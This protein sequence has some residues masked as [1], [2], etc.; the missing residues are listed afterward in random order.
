MK[1]VDELRE[2]LRNDYGITSE[3]ELDIALR[4]AKRPDIGLFVSMTG[5][6]NDEEKGEKGTAERQSSHSAA[7][8][9]G[10][11]NMLPELCPEKP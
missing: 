3:A 5:R 6:R 1:I 4:K 2:M 11:G 8:G 9:F 7:G 10:G